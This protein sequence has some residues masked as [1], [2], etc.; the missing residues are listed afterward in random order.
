[1]LFCLVNIVHISL[2]LS[3]L[4]TPL[5]LERGIYLCIYLCMYCYLCIYRIHVCMYGRTYIRMYRMY[6]CTDNTIPLVLVVSQKSHLPPSPKNLRNY[7]PLKCGNWM[8]I[9][10]SS[11]L[12]ALVGMSPTEHIP[13][14]SHWQAQTSSFLRLK[15][16]KSDSTTIV[17]WVPKR[18]VEPL[19]S[20]FESDAFPIFDDGLWRLQV[21]CW[22]FT[23]SWRRVLPS[24]AMG[25]IA[26]F[27]CCLLLKF[28]EIPESR[29]K[30]VTLAKSRRF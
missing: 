17:W 12:V 22:P 24:M 4:S 10:V 13:L 1:M 26:V 8:S 28:H 19:V 25:R 2:F 5:C 11:F 7:Q 9:Q 27:R 14:I 3:H 18:K 23:I 30:I 20:P 6:V 21:L 15:I 16:P 29:K